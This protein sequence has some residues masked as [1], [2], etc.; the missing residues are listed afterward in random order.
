L[1]S[2]NPGAS[3]AAIGRESAFLTRDHPLDYG[4]GEG[5]PLAKFEAMGGRVLMVGAPWD[6]MTLLHLAEHRARIAGKRVIRFET[7][8]AAA[9]GVAWR[10]QEEFDTSEPVADNLP[11]DAFERIVSDFVAAGGGRRGQVGQAPALLVEAG[12][13]VAFGIGWLERRARRG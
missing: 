12:E 11:A 8:F 9:G 13:V 7:P 2:G 1:R 4:Y 3:V 6:T 5:S 10:F